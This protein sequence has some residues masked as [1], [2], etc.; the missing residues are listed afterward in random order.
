[1]PEEV[2]QANYK[3]LESTLDQL[4]SAITI[5]TERLTGKGIGKD[6]EYKGLVHNILAIA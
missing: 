1:M 4:T 5:Q 2:E 6:M 3:R